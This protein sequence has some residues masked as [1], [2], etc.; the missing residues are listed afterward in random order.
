MGLFFQT[1]RA[2]LGGTIADFLYTPVWWYSRGLLRQFQ[3]V[4]GSL[5]ARY[6]ALALDVWVK[7]IGTPMY[8]QYDI[9]G[10]IISFVMR[11]AQIVGRLFVLVV[12]AALLLTWLMVW[13]LI[14]V[15]V[16]YLIV[17]QIKSAVRV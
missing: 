8:G 5:G 1:F 9:S 7:N 10:R 15:G 14:P 2:V 17:I 6:E 4:W 16:L 12:W 13:V 3:G 11:L